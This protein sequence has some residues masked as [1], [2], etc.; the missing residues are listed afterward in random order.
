MLCSIEYGPICEDAV[1]PGRGPRLTMGEHG[2]PL[3]V[4]LQVGLYIFFFV[5]FLWLFALSG[6]A[7]LI[8]LWAGSALGTFMSAVFTN[9]VTLRIYEGR[10]LSDI[11]FHWNPASKWNLAWGLAGGIAGALMALSG[12]LLVGAASMQA[13]PG[14][15]HWRTFVFITVIL[16]SILRFLGSH[17]ASNL[18][19]HLDR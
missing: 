19:T 7:S 10:Q 4:G 1:P 13:D 12:P 9:V 3:R 17:S 16:S 15:A 11:G 18:D 14:E 2:D 5:L 8:G 6:L